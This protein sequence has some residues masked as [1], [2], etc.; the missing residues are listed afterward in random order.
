MLEKLLARRLEL[1]KKAREYHSKELTAYNVY[2]E[3]KTIHNRVRQQLA[4]LDA[5]LKKLTVK[6]EV[7]PVEE[8]EQNEQR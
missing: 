1:K 7:E 2:F 5:K 4:N 3:L 6:V 8:G